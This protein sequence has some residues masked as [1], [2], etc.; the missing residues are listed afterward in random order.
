MRKLVIVGIAMV[1]MG[2]ATSREVVESGS[3]GTVT[4]A[5]AMEGGVIERGGERSR[6]TTYSDLCISIFKEGGD[7]LIDTVVNISGA[8]QFVTIPGVSEGVNYSAVVWTE[9]E[10][11]DTIHSPVIQQFNVVATEQ[12]TIT[13]D[14]LSQCGSIIFQ[15]IDL[16]T[17]VDSLFLQFE[18]DVG[19]FTASE[20]HSTKEFLSLDKIPYGTTGQLAFKITRDG[21]S[22]ISDW[23]TTFTFSREHFS[24]SFSLINNGTIVTDITLEKPGTSTFSATG[25]TTIALSNESGELV[26]SEFCGSGGSNS[27]SGEFI[28]IYN[29]LDVEFVATEL[30]LNDG[31]KSHTLTDVTIAAGDYFVVATE[32][33]SFWNPD[34]TIPLDITST[35]GVLSLSKDGTLI[36]YLIFFND[37]DAGWEYI[38]SSSKTSWTLNENQL[39]ASGNNSGSSWSSA[40]SVV[41]NGEDQWHGSAG[42]SGR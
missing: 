29:P 7:I 35:S 22:T 39:T 16:P 9:D 38:S 19:T 12:T 28:E 37:T 27:S 10:V 30:I 17:V 15:L 32:V 24:V 23:D 40:T 5:V 21:G 18:T 8:M 13:F 14:L 2:C 25:D 26:I 1:L 3:D 31:K 42:V 11:G 20:E 33:G 4:V 34:L 36:D 6:A 41:M